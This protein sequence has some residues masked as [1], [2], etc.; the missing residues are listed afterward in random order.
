MV[1]IFVDIAGATI[2]IYEYLVGDET[3]CIV[4]NTKSGTRYIFWCRANVLWLIELQI[5]SVYDIK[6]AYTETVEGYLRLYATDIELSSAKQLN[7]INTQNNRSAILLAR[8]LY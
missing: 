4:L 6:H 1:L 7:A 3:G 8:K 2:H 5:D